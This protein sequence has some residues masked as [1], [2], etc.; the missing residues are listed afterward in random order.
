MAWSSVWLM[1]GTTG[2]LGGVKPYSENDFQVAPAPRFHTNRNIHSKP[3]TT[4]DQI[5]WLLPHEKFVEVCLRPGWWGGGELEAWSIRKM[6]GLEGGRGRVHTVEGEHWSCNGHPQVG[7]MMMNKTECKIEK[8]GNS[9]K[10]NWQS[11]VNDVS[12]LKKIKI[13]YISLDFSFAIALKCYDDRMRHLNQKSNIHLIGKYYLTNRI[14]E[15][16]LQSL[17]FRKRIILKPYLQF[18]PHITDPT[19]SKSWL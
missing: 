6:V 2:L 5:Q 9:L 18:S 17:L 7:N 10:L 13:F 14:W 8:W 1:A 16:L 15:T 19:F 11:W 12:S 4:K 3:T